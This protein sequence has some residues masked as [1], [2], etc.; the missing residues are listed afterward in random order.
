SVEGV[1]AAVEELHAQAIARAFDERASVLKRSYRGHAIV[2]KVLDDGFE[3][4]GQILQ[5]LLAPD[6]DTPGQGVFSTLQSLS[7][8]DNFQTY[9][10]YRPSTPGSIWVTLNV[11][12]WSWSGSATMPGGG[13]VVGPA[14]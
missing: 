5:E 6:S 2:V 4:N 9:L 10:M 14:D 1:A 3:Y 8:N 7:I 13:W 12:N 11:L